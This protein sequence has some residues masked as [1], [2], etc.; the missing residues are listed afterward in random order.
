MSNIEGM[1]YEEWLGNLDHS[2]KMQVEILKAWVQTRENMPGKDPGGRPLIDDH[3]TTEDIMDELSPM[4]PMKHETIAYFLAFHEFGF[5]TDDSGAVKW[6][7]W[8]RA[9]DLL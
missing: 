9:P 8:R 5:T 3:K 4:I 7:I 1:R 6:A 2:E